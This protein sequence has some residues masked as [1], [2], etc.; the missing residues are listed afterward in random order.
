MFSPLKT[1][2][3][4]R[5][6]LSLW[7]VVTLTV[8]LIASFLVYRAI[9]RSIERQTQESVFIK[10]DELQV[11]TALELLHSEG[12][13][14]MSNYIDYLDR[15]LGGRHHLLDAQGNDLRTGQNFSAYLPSTRNF[16]IRGNS[17]GHWQL[18]HYF[19]DKNIWFYVESNFDNQERWSFW[20][21]YLLVLGS[22]VALTLLAWLTV[23][24]PLQ[25][26][27]AAL[28]RFGRGDLAVRIHPRRHD[29]I[30]QLGRTFDQMAARL[31]RLIVSERQLLA[32]ISHELRSPLSRL[33]VAT[34]LARTSPDR[35]QALNR[36]QREVDRITQLVSDIVEINMA[37]DDPLLKGIKLADLGSIVAVILSDCTLEIEARH[38]SL[39][40]DGSLDA[41]VSG[42][43]E[44]LRRAIEN[45]LRNAIRYAPEGSTLQVFLAN[46]PT[47]AYIAIRDF[48][49]G[50]PEEMLARI[51]APF[52]RV[53]PSRTPGSGTGL[54]LSIA[55]RAIQL[56][57][58]S[59]EAEN[60]HPGLRVRIAL[61]LSA[62][63]PPSS[64]LPTS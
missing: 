1:R 31:E 41:I 28:A 64:L 56:H 34:R 17:H 23:L 16:Y 55:Q 25:S 39:A 29:E 3:R 22:T 49:P 10:L 19:A 4:L 13:V 60:A 32:D 20:P 26:I 57:H 33:T 59:I 47:H 61:P 58:G 51:F 38:C 7:V 50:V 24:T 62:Q 63:D 36:I 45:V 37:E 6:S 11:E 18:T 5:N 9:T 30:G 27:A 2:L 43:P 44:L 12:R 42:S 53:D 48:G 21:F 15:L 35:D 40:I 46:T 8:T 54:G 52:V 14:A